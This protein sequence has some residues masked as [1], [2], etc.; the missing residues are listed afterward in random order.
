VADDIGGAGGEGDL[1]RGYGERDMGR[2]ARESDT[3]VRRAIDEGLTLG[4]GCG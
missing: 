3:A 1:L 2:R 4:R